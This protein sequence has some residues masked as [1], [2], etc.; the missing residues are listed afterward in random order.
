MKQIFDQEQLKPGTQIAS[1]PDHV[2]KLTDPEVE[3]GFITRTT[4]AGYAFCRFWQ[5]DNITELRTK[6]C[7]EGV[8]YKNLV[9][10]DSVPQSQVEE[11]MVWIKQEAK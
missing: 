10:I 1:V 9:V 4:E 11:A 5:R 3:Y 6:S 2:S 8:P 7:S